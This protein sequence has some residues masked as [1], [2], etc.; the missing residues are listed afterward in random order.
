MIILR[1][2]KEYSKLNKN[3]KAPL[4]RAWHRT[5]AFMTGTVDNPR[6]LA[7]LRKNKQVIPATANNTYIK[8][9]QAASKQGGIF[10]YNQPSDFRGLFY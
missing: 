4:R 7:N 2:Q 10:D 1:K 8:G 9:C 3:V 5:Q 6:G